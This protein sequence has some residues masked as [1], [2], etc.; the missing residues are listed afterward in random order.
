MHFSSF[1]HLK[2]SK[3]GQL[4]STNVS[5][6]VNNGIQHQCYL[7]DNLC[8]QYFAE[9]NWKK[10]SLL[11]QTC[12]VQFT[13]KL[14]LEMMRFDRLRIRRKQSG[15][16]SWRRKDIS[17]EQITAVELLYEV[18][19][20]IKTIKLTTY[21]TE[22]YESRESSNKSKLFKQNLIRIYRIGG[23]QL[24]EQITKSRGSR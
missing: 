9:S 21:T 19:N 6:N 8:L 22:L 20:M 18:R 2:G 16:C 23:L 4:V 10:I 12:I 7:L 24:L 11:L 3:G 1:L 15:D 14:L 17:Q 5:N 13:E